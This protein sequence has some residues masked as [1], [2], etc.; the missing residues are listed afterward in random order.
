MLVSLCEETIKPVFEEG[1]C[2]YTRMQ[3]Q[4]ACFS[5]LSPHHSSNSNKNKRRRLSGY[6]PK[7]QNTRLLYI[8]VFFCGTSWV[9][10][11]SDGM[12]Q[13]MPR[14]VATRRGMPWDITW[15]HTTCHGMSHAKPQHSTISRDIP[16]R[17]QRLPRHAM[18]RRD[19][20]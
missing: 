14:H 1:F 6:P 4:A 2:T 18:G 3:D 15:E 19:V 11:G 16:R 8:F 17:S 7:R 9:P 20:S 13:G 5:I 10:M 12:S